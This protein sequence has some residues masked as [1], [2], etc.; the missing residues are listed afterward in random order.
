MGVVEHLTL[1][2]S[3]ESVFNPSPNACRGLSSL[4]FSLSF[5]S[6]F[7]DLFS[8]FQGSPH[9]WSIAPFPLLPLLLLESIDLIESDC[10]CWLLV[11]LTWSFTVNPSTATQ[12]AGTMSS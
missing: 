1:S 6:S 12:M 2:S 5:L 8:G 10:T 4:L 7:S 11:L 3:K 9:C